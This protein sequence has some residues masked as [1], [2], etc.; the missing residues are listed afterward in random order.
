MPLQ[1]WETRLQ[2]SK[3]RAVGPLVRAGSGFRT[4]ASKGVYS[5]YEVPSFDEFWSRYLAVCEIYRSRGQNFKADLWRP[6]AA[7]GGVITSDDACSCPVL[8]AFDRMPIGRRPAEKF[9]IEIFEHLPFPP[10]LWCASRLVY[11]GVDSPKLIYT[12][13]FKVMLHLL[14]IGHNLNGQF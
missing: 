2:G 1:S 9:M 8:C 13:L 11:I 10:V 6:L 3:Y 5:M 4:G 12:Y 7:V 14:P